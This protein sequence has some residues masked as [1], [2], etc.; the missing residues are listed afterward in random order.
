MNIAAK[1]VAIV[2][3]VAVLWFFTWV[4]TGSFGVGKTE[5]EPNVKV[6]AIHQP[7]QTPPTASIGT[8]ETPAQAAAPKPS[9]TP[10]TIG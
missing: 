1:L 4:G 7:A 8:T 3:G 2:F 5:P 6:E 9:T 10:T